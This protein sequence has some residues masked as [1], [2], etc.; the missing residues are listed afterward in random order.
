MKV[1][2]ND[3]HSQFY[4]AMEWVDGRLLRQL[5]NEQCK[6]SPERATNIVLQIASALEYIHAHGVVHR[7]LKPK[8][9]WWIRKTAS[10]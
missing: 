4:M 2:P 1:F 3:N 9:S 10:S 8:T 5:L 7:D 6:F